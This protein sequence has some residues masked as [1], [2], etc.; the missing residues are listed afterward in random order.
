[1]SYTDLIH[2][3]TFI[4]KG[5]E[6]AEFLSNRMDS[7]RNLHENDMQTLDRLLLELNHYRE[8]NLDTVLRNGGDFRYRRCDERREGRFPN[9]RDMDQDD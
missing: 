6:R 2:T 9:K 5:M 4:T 1:M 7:Y 8:K 3:L